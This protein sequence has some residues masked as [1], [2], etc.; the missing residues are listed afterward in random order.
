MLACR[1]LNASAKPPAKLGV[2]VDL[3]LSGVARPLPFI[4]MLT[5]LSRAGIIGGGFFAAGRLAGGS[6]G[7]G[8]ALTAGRA[9]PLAGTGVGRGCWRVVVVVGGGGGG[10]GAAAWVGS[11]TR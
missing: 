10:G 2:G 6:G 9:A 4:V 8:L 7:A 11:S 1:A 5:A 3:P